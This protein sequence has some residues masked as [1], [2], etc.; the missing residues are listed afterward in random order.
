MENNNRNNNKVVRFAKALFHA[1]GQDEAY[2]RIA[3]KDT[4]GL[5]FDHISYQEF[6]TKFML[7]LGDIT[8]DRIWVPIGYVQSSGF[9]ALGSSVL[10]LSKKIDEV[11]VG[12]KLGFKRPRSANEWS[13]IGF[14]VVE[15]TGVY[16]NPDSLGIVSDQ[17]LNLRER[18]WVFKLI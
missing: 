16:D 8:R 7:T 15:V 12:D 4:V 13:P 2:D 3:K 6:V 18:D 1:L 14:G 10:T 5:N 11:S 17:F 9:Q